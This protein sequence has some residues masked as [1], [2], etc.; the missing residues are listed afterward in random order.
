MT[1]CN[2]KSKYVSAEGQNNSLPQWPVFGL[3]VCIVG[4]LVAPVLHDTKSN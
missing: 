3:H 4:Q 1:T 2:I